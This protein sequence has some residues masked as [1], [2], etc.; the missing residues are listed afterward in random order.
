MDTQTLFNNCVQ[1]LLDHTSF[2]GPTDSAAQN[3][4]IGEF[5][6]IRRSMDP[7]VWK[8]EVQDMAADYDV[9]VDLEAWERHAPSAQAQHA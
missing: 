9:T 4:I 6:A 5:R 3:S 8:T 7:R 1:A 2:P